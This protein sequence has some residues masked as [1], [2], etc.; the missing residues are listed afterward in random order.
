MKHKA[1]KELLR[2]V[3]A[4]F[5]SVSAVLAV[6]IFMNGMYLLG[7]PDPEDVQ[8]VVAE[9]PG[10]TDEKK[11][12]TDRE[13]VEQAVKLTGFLRYALFEEP[14]SGGS[15]MITITYVLDDGRTVSVSADRETVWWKGRPRAIKDREMFIN[16][17]EGIFSSRSKP[18]VSDGI[19]V[20]F[21]GAVKR[22]SLTPLSGP[23][24]LIFRIMNLGDSV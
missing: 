10:V 5:L 21:A 11:E 17:A 12:F 4:V 22:H 9:Y 13:H 6:S 23:V 1:V 3:L 20:Y 2:F 24:K 7:I 8:S 19:A 15:P 16:L 14:V 18:S